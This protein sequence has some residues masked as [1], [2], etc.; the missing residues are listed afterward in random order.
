[1]PESP[2]TRLHSMPQQNPP[3]IL[4]SYSWEEEMPFLFHHCNSSES[5]FRCKMTISL[6]L[7]TIKEQ[8]MV[9]CFETELEFPKAPSTPHTTAHPGLVQCLAQSQWIFS[10]KR[11]SVQSSMWRIQLAALISANRSLAT[12]PSHL[13]KDVSSVFNRH[14][15]KSTP[16]LK[17][18]REKF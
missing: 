1:M 12:K 16:E 15:N 11:L 9:L 5:S 8:H 10:G 7:L 14:L 18:S 6:F 17:P 3:L 4:D 13:F 2:Q